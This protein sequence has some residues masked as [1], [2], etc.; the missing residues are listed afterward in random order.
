MRSPHRPGLL[1]LALLCVLA[2]PAARAADGTDADGADDD[3]VAAGSC[4]GVE[5]LDQPSTSFTQDW[6]APV[7]I[8]QLSAGFGSAGT[9]WSHRH[10]G[11]DFA[12]PV[13][14]PVRAVGAGRVVSVS[15]GG[16][17]GIQIVLRHPDGY[18]TQYAHLA[19][20]AVGPGESVTTGQWIGRSGTTGNSTG[21]HLHFEVRVVPEYG[22]A[23][24]PVPWLA[25]RGV[26]LGAPGFD[27]QQR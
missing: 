14:T 11:Q 8:Y 24:D 3:A 18:F 1:V 10:T 13:G 17:F 23:V 27:A 12:V 21:P 7:E 22:S 5:R 26:P 16:P 6:V 15:C 9:R 25:E 19:S 2:L 20:V 4:P